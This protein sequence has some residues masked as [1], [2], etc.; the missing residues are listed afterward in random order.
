MGV[1]EMR[2]H[3]TAYGSGELQEV[4]LRTIIRSEL[5]REPQLGQELIALTDDCRRANLIGQRLQSN[6]NADILEITSPNFDLT[7]IRAPGPGPDWAESASFGSRHAANSTAPNLSQPAGTGSNS[8]GSW[9]LADG[10]SEVGAPLYPGAVLRERF[11]LVEELGHGGM[12]VVYKA[13]DRSRGDVKDRYV[14]IKVLSEGFKRHPLAVKSLQREARK[15][16]RLA[17]PNI[18]AVHD[19]DR[20]GGNVFMVM[21]LLSG[22]SLDH[23]LREDGQGGIPMGPARDIIRSLAAA[24]SY[25]HEHDIVHCDFKPGNAFLGRDGRVKVLDF[26]IARAAPSTAA[27]KPDTTLFDAGQLGAV[28]PAYA[29]CELLQGESPDV[30]DDVYSFACVVYELLSG[31]HPYQ[32]IDAIKAFQSGLEPRPL[33]NLSRPQWRALKQGLSFRRA[34]RCPTIDS[35]AQQLL[36]PRPTARLWLTGGAAAAAVVAVTGA[37]IL[38]RHP[39]SPAAVATRTI[40]AAPA[41]E[42]EAAR[43]PLPQT[44][45]PEATPPHPLS[46]AVAVPAN[47]SG[48][49]SAAKPAAAPQAP[50]GGRAAEH[51]HVEL[52]VLKEQFENQ[53]IVGDVEGASKTGTVLIRAEPGSTYATADVPRIIAQAYVLRAKSQFLA[54]QVN[55]ALQTLAEGRRKYGRSM[56]LK[57]QEIKYVAAAD[58]YDRISTAVVLNL[59]MTRQGLDELKG[60]QGDDFEATDQMLAQTLADRI[61]DQRAAGRTS[62]ADN[63]KKAGQ[64][65]FPKYV[66]ILDRGQAGKLS[67]SPLE[68]TDQ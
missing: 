41:P 43:A 54:G 47:T 12:G 1:S 58:L 64:Q 51:R 3:F 23:V 8:T 30:R 31:V 19:F 34:D 57:D 59:S 52:E 46:P 68:V 14:A 32:R 39:V 37:L 53:A 35:L 55:A 67:A 21:E 27:D 26:G 13:F 25:A 49:S 48:N 15:A 61:A 17:H 36:S 40:P 29:S 60:M 6:I 45:A 18:V 2:R 16:Q 9:G 66:Q 4:Q 20:D 65:L 56:E 38:Q 50:V 10:L 33:R 22:R 62:V 11:V 28:S 44:P 24:L 42:N 7:K 5:S 63:L